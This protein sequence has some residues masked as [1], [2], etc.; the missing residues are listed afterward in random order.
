TH[1]GRRID[2]QYFACE[3]WHVMMVSIVDAVQNFKTSKPCKGTCVS[4]ITRKEA[5]KG[6]DVGS[7][8][9]GHIVDQRCTPKD[10]ANGKT[11]VCFC[12]GSDCNTAA[13]LFDPEGYAGQKS[14]ALEL[15]KI[16]IIDEPTEA[17]T[18]VGVEATTTVPDGPSGAGGDDA[19]S[20]D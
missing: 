8:C 20:Y 14:R 18:A 15:R 19:V 6:V 17:T 1:V 13:R 5:E 3:N 7:S 12:A 4:R 2:L 10:D 11:M 9:W 16:G